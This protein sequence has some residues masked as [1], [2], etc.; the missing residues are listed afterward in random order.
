MILVQDVLL[1]IPYTYFNEKLM[2]QKLLTEA[3]CDRY[4][5]Q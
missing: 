4:F 1:K 2:K 3:I 5:A